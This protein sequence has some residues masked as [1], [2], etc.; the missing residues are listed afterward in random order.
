MQR[1]LAPLTDARGSKQV[2]A[3]GKARDGMGQYQKSTRWMPLG[4]IELARLFVGEKERY[5]SI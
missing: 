2:V 1:S 5:F 4:I 3:E